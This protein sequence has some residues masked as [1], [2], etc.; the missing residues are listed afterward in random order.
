MDVSNPLLTVNNLYTQFDT[1]R[2]IARAVD[3]VSFSL[4]RGKTL[5]IVGES[6]SGKS[7]LSRTIIDI[8]AKDD[9]VLFDGEIIFEGC[10][11]RT[12]SE[13][14]MQEIRGKE[15]AMVFQ[16]PMSSLNPVK[17]IGKQITEV[18]TKRLGMSSHLAKIRAV[19]LIHSVGIPDPEQQLGRYPM[20]LS[21]GMRQRIAIA[22]AIAS[23]PKLLIADEPTTALD[24]TIQAQILELLKEQQTKYNMSI[25]LI[26]HNL[27]I[28]SG[29]TDDVAV[30]YAGKIVEK[31]STSELISN[32]VMP[33]TKALMN[34]APSLTNT[35]HTRLQAIPGLPPNL[36]N[37]PNGCSF[38][39][40]CSY[41]DEKC[42]KY[43]PDQTLLKD[44]MHSFACWHPLNRSL[45]EGVVK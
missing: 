35:P 37:L 3:G 19:E 11:L 20:H 30:M 45:A 16:D 24:V 43:T 8:L 25:I 18:L 38:H 4:E 21:G 34:C 42:N 31:C 14:E 28:V 41:N 23:E 32:P 27:G 26:T 9:S 6:G 36:L 15:I 1:P 29:Y 22:I 5:G 2:G 10:D 7:V 13:R 17:K 39:S 44:S 33:Y 40:R 12:L